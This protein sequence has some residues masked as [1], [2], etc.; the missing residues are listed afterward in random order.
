MYTYCAS[1]AWASRT[2]DRTDKCEIIGLFCKR[3][4]Q[5][6]LYSAC[7][8]RTESMHIDIYTCTYMY[9]FIYTCTYM[10]IFIYIYI[11]MY[12]WVCIYTST[13]FRIYITLPAQIVQK[14]LL[15]ERYVQACIYMCVYNWCAYIWH[16]MYVHW[17]MYT[18]MYR[19]YV[20]VSMSI[21]MYWDGVCT[22]IMCQY[23]CTDIMC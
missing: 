12:V 19:S 2:E 8:S 22:S 15:S 21:S 17:C 4:L 9:I 10:Y 23:R 14:A 11:C 5:K 16:M 18:L 1:T 6:R 13:Y 3:A 7:A 20:S